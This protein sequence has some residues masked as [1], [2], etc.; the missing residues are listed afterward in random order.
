ME[1]D[2]NIPLQILALWSTLDKFK[3]RE[4]RT[5][6]NRFEQTPRAGR[7]AFARSMGIVSID[8]GPLT[9]PCPVCGR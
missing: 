5:L 8:T 2:E 3:R 7:D 4:A 9:R 1:T 6:I